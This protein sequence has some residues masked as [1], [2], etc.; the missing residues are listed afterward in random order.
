MERIKKI[1]ADQL[2]AHSKHQNTRV[3]MWNGIAITIRYLIELKEIPDVIDSIMNACYDKTHDTFMPEMIDFIFKVNIITRY[4][5]IELPIDIEKRYE[6]IYN[7]DIYNTIV[8]YVNA[9]Q[10]QSLKRTI[11]MLAFGIK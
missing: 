9:E 2:L 8:S 1:T 11:D 10:V 4:A 3:I 5:Y 6:V 7:T